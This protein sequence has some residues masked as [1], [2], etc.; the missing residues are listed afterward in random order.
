MTQNKK[1]SKKRINHKKIL[2]RT[3]PKNRGTAWKKQIVLLFRDEPQMELKDY[4]LNIRRKLG[5][6]YNYE[7]ALRFLE[8]RVKAEDI[9]KIQNKESGEIEY[10]LNP[11]L[12][13]KKRGGKIKYDSLTEYL[14]GESVNVNSFIK[15]TGISKDAFYRI[16][17]SD[18]APREPTLRVAI[19]VWKAAHKRFPIESFL[20][21]GLNGGAYCDENENGVSQKEALSIL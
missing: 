16:S 8:Q 12:E 4:L 20:L 10:R 18:R 14:Q 3:M 6:K 15:K 7:K 5:A 17:S 19:K 1:V 11:V 21:D 13:R 2:N 9:L